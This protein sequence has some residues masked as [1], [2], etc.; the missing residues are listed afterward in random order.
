MKNIPL[1]DDICT[2]ANSPVTTHWFNCNGTWYY[3]TVISAGIG[4]GPSVSVSGDQITGNVQHQANVDLFYDPDNDCFAVKFSSGGVEGCVGEECV[5]NLPSPT[6]SITKLANALYDVGHSLA[7]G[8]YDQ[9]GYTPS[10][11]VIVA[12]AVFFA[13]VLAF[14]VAAGAP[15]GV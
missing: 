13:V 14:G 10:S 6:A 8:M 15:A 5:P 4:Y 7:T 2:Y 3:G 11:E 1:A 12:T 9:L